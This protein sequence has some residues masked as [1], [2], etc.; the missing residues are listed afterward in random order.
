LST[1]NRQIIST[2]KY[3]RLNICLLCI[4]KL[5]GKLKSP[6]WKHFNNLY[7]YAQRQF[8]GYCATIILLLHISQLFMYCKSTNYF[9]TGNRLI[10]CLLCIE[11][12][13]D[14]CESPIRKHFDDLYDYC[15]KT[16]YLGTAQHTITFLLRISQLFVYCK[17]TNYFTSGNRV[18]V[19]LFC[20]EKLYHNFKSPIWKRFEGLY[21]F[22]S[23]PFLFGYC[24]STI[25]LL[26]ISQLFINCKS[27]H[28]ITNGNRLNISLLCTEK[29]YENF[30]SPIWKHFDDLLGYCAS[31]NYLSTVNRPII[32]PLEIVKICGN[33]A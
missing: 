18:N 10:I 8:L 11:I 21:G 26:R 28:Y 12:L 13:Y 16:N 27:T 32:S 24:A 22:C 29:L 4:E 19:W 14:N 15:A 33:C 3:N 17:S 7:G 9:T 5:Y 1:A 2:P 30:K 31:L 23:K 6:I 25:L 20:I